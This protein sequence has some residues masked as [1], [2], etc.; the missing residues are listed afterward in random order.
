MKIAIITDHIP[1]FYAHSINTTKT[2]Q[3]FFILGHE[4]EIL[5]INRFNELKNRIKFRN[6]H[7]FYH[8]NSEIKIKYFIDFFLTFFRE[9]R[10]FH[11]V[12]NEISNRI[13]KMIHGITVILDPEINISYYCSKKGFDFVYCRRTD[14]TAFY[15]IK[16]KIPT[17]IESH[18]HYT[19]ISSMLKKI[20]KLKNDK[21]F[22]GTI[23]ITKELKEHHLKAE[24]SKEK[25]IIIEDAVEL[26]Q[27]D[28][29]TNNKT[30]LRK[31]LT[32]PL[33]KKIILYTGTLRDGRGINTIL[34]SA[35]YLREEDLIFCFIGGN[36]DEIKEWKKYIKI[37]ELGGNFSFLGF[38]Q[39]KLIPLY[40]K[41]ADI[42]LAPYS[43]NCSTI[44]WMSPIKLFEYMA[45]KVPIIA[46]NVRRIK[47]IC[48]NQESLFFDV[49]NPKDLSEKIKIL[50]NN[51]DLQDKLVQN[52]YNKAK[53]FSYINRCK[54][55]IDF[56]KRD[57]I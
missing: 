24:L 43:L 1:S 40:V 6:I 29:I 39:N 22:R 52:A 26:E 55:I 36:K 3:G 51:R 25:I 38:K 16:S 13:K 19:K 27:F 54:K 7:D 48:N 11:E 23:T 45:S 14:K 47:E 46:S 50:L 34:N 28:A 57:D 18:D 17:V 37:N 15:C 21:Y 41:S 10:Y 56:I 2:A 30:L 32:L 4:V 8:I 33:G 53:E 12:I 20:Y 49:D 44:E 31:N 9:S 42:L 5:A 35:K